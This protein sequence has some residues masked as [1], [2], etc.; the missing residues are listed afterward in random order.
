M[1]KRLNLFAG[2]SPLNQLL[3]RVAEDPERRARCRPSV[4]NRSYP[5]LAA[6]SSTCIG[7][8]R[9]STPKPV[10]L[11]GLVRVS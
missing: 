8:R 2:A 11:P 7:L 4:L 9:E 1:S 3:L 10:S 5:K 6:K